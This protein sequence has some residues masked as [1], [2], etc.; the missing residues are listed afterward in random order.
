M[1][2]KPAVKKARRDSLQARD[3]SVFSAEYS[4]TECYDD[5]ALPPPSSP[6]QT[7]AATAERVSEQPTRASLF[8]FQRLKR[9]LETVT[10]NVAPSLVILSLKC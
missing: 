6:P 2:F 1:L 4:D 5:T 10:V 3:P 9:A 7:I 8:N